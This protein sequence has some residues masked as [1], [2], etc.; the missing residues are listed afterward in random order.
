MNEFMTRLQIPY[1]TKSSTKRSTAP[2]A[3]NVM[4]DDGNSRGSHSDLAWRTI[5]GTRQQECL[6]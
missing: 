3:R 2:A 1:P 6:D 5:A 4:P